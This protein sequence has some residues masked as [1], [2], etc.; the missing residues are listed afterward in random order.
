MQAS[1]HNLWPR[2]EAI[3]KQLDLTFSRGMAG[4]ASD[5]CHL[6][7]RGLRV[8]DGLGIPGGGEHADHEH[9]LLDALQPTFVRNT[10]LLYDL[11]SE[12]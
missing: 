10:L 11:A 4:G 6:A 12:E 8:M 3:C 7:A 9:I 1:R 2:L 5:G